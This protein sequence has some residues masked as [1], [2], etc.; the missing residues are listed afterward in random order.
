MGWMVRRATAADV[1]GIARVNVEA[2]R[3]TYRGIVPDDV[4]DGLDVARR[5]QGWSRW[6][7]MPPPDAV[8]V[9]TRSDS[10]DPD[11]IVAYCAVCAVREAKDAHPTLPTGELVAI[12]TDPTVLGTGAGH[13]VH[14]AGVAALAEAGFRHAVLWVFEDNPRARAFYEQHGWTSDG[15]REEFEVGDARPLEVRYS[16]PLP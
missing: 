15:V 9:A 14:E 12:Y 2:W 3:H 8:F 4:L 5:E 7:S 10:D 16:R 1:P 11:G 13:A 6:V